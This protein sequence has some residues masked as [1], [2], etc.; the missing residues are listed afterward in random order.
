MS[1]WVV[2]PP[3]SDSRAPRVA[4]SSTVSGSITAASAAQRCSRKPCRSRFSASP[5]RRVIGRCVCRLTRPGISSLPRASMTTVPSSAAVRVGC[6]GADLG[7]DAVVD[8]DGGV[9]EDGVALVDG[10]DVAGV[11]D[12]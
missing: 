5:R 4:P 8:D 1:S 6:R 7:D 2:H 3:S 9:R 11:L 10:D 12:A